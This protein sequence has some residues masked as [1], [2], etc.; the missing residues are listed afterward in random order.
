MKHK[1]YLAVLILFAFFSFLAFENKVPFTE[2]SDARYSEIAYETLVY[3]HWLIPTQNKIMHITKPPLTYWIT[4]LGFKIFGVNEFGGRF[5]SGIFGMLSSLLVFFI[6]FTLFKDE[7]IAFFSGIIFCTTPLVI[8]ASRIVTTD[9]FLLTSML[10]SLYSFLKYTETK[11]NRYVWLF[12]IALG[13][14]GF[15]KGPLG[16]IQVLPI[17]TLYLYLENK[18][19]IAKKLFAPLPIAVSLIIAFWWFVYVFLKIPGAFD[20]L[21]G[22]QLMSRFS[23]KGFGHPKPFYF[24]GKI[25]F[26]TA[27]P[28][29]F[30]ALFSIKEIVADIKKSSQ[31]KFL[32]ITF[33]YPLILFSI[34]KSK[35]S[36]YIL[37]SLAALAIITAKALTEKR[38]K[39]KIFTLLAVVET[40][41]IVYAK[42]KG[43]L[44]EGNLSLLLV[45]SIIIFNGITVFSKKAEWTIGATAV[46]IIAVLLIVVNI[47]SASPEKY[48]FTMKT[49]AKYINNL[50]PKPNKVYLVGFNSRSFVLYTKIHPVETRFDKEFIYSDPVTKSV[51]IKLGDLKKRWETES[52]P[53]VIVKKKDAQKY[54]NTFKNSLILFS[55]NRF[56][57]LTK[58]K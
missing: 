5:F 22:K 32:A 29:I 56:S 54:L 6:A 1:K 12:W 21:F 28:W 46:K 10:F 55:D 52:N 15:I 53:V 19:E 47:V 7:K 41:L 31:M 33:A 36:L 4:A 34:P 8:G 3:N 2:T 20:Y 57:V 40:A 39:C 49:T 18:K 43:V 37:L 17:I 23:S 35:L 25:I 24:Y 16:Y 9:I 58:R 30:A 14:S 44:P 38:E 50:N 27:Y 11:L 13:L 51:L 48:F 42:Y 26:Y 45:A